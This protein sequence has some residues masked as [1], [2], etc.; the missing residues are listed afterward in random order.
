MLLE[1]A[2]NWTVWWAKQEDRCAIQTHDDGLA[3]YKR[4]TANDQWQDNNIVTGESFF[5]MGGEDHLSPS[6]QGCF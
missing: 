1:M 5:T 4:E 6:S 2:D 3:Q